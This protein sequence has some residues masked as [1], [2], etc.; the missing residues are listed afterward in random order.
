MGAGWGEKGI[1]RDKRGEVQSEGRS[2]RFLV[3][4][5]IHLDR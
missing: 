5:L 3:L 4:K 2:K 1:G